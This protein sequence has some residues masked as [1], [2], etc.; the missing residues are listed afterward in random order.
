M[1]SW[2]AEALTEASSLVRWLERTEAQVHPVAKITTHLVECL[3]N[4]NAIITCGNGGSMCEAMHFAEELSGRYRQDR[5]AFAARA[6]CDP[7]HLTCVANDFG[8]D[9]V[10]ARGVEAWGRRGD[11]LII[12]STS[13]ASRNIVHAA[14]AARERGLFVVGLLGKNGGDTLALC[15]AAIVVP[16]SASERIQEIHQKIVHLLIE[17]VERTL[18]PDLYP[19]N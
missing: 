9:Q 19:M 15:D 3:S 1:A 6:I 5:R 11:M 12:F 8:F 16:A 14:H 13:G 17:G 18:L 7:A 4:G 10:F 2:I